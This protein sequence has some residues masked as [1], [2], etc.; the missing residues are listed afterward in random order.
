MLTLDQSVLTHRRFPGQKVDCPVIA[1]FIEMAD[2]EHILF[3][4][5]LLPALLEDRNFLPA[6]QADCI[7]RYTGEDGIRNRLR[8]VGATPCIEGNADSRW[9][10]AFEINCN[11]YMR[12]FSDTYFHYSHKAKLKRTCFPEGANRLNLLRWAF[13]KWAANN[14]DKQGWSAARGL[15]AAVNTELKCK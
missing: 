8:A 2:D 15:I 10:E 5:G 6:Y 11:Q 4:T 9:G 7:C 1:A 3:D 13:I 14:T 12:G